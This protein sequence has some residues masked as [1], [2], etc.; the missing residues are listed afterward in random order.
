MDGI[1]GKEIYELPAELAAKA[2][3]YADASLAEA[4]RTSY[5]GAFRRCGKWC[6]L[7]GRPSLPASVDTIMLYLAA[8]AEQCRPGYLR[9]MLTGIGRAHRAAGLPFDRSAFSRILEGIDRSYGFPPRQAPAIAIEELRALVAGLP[10]TL[11][12][13]RDRMMLSLAFAAALSPSEFVGLD[14]G[15]EESRCTGLVEITKEG[16]RLTLRSRRAGD[17]DIVKAVPRGG[18]PC[19]VE[20]LERWL[21]LAGIGNGPIAREVTPA[22]KVG[23]GRLNLNSSQQIIKRIIYVQAKQAGMDEAAACEKAARYNFGSLRTGFIVSAIRAGASSESIA[24]HLGWKSTR[25]ISH[26][27]RKCGAFHKHPVARVL[28]SQ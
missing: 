12:G 15:R 18:N 20:A 10:H 8:Q 25:P 2:R 28:A 27:R 11:K 14:I 24:R 7:C 4:T 22:S 6:E 21:A 3:F 9:R 1:V 17:P 5:E 26:Y 19:P 13:A 23:R 16:L